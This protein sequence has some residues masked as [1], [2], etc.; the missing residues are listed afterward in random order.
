MLMKKPLE[1]ASIKEPNKKRDDLL[2]KNG[3]FQSIF[4]LFSVRVLSTKMGDHERLFLTRTY[5]NKFPQRGRAETLA[6]GQGFEPR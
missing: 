4:L 3:D 2:C 6:P 1:V 5:F